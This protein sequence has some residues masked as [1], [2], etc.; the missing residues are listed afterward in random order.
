MRQVYTCLES[1]FRCG[2]GSKG[3]TEGKIRNNWGEAG[4]VLDF[5]ENSEETASALSRN[6]L[7]PCLRMDW[8]M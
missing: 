1:P 7:V 5:L 8:H 3:D 6:C 4:I 2:H